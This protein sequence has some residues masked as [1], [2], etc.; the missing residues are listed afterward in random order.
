MYSTASTTTPC[1]AS[2]FT[3]Q[4]SEK[5]GVNSHDSVSLNQRSETLA[6]IFKRNGYDTHA[7]P[8]GPIVDK[9]DLNRGF[10]EFNYRD[11]NKNLDD[12][13]GEEVK[14]K[15]M[16]FQEPFFICIYGSFIGQS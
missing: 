10:D 15:I 11:R 4:Y 8:T 5:N 9:T 6:E 13:W 14:S 1:V 12:L 16:S 7:F 2:I 3:G